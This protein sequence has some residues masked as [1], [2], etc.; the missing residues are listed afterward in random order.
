MALEID[1]NACY[2]DFRYWVAE[3]TNRP[4]KT[5]P[6]RNYRKLPAVNSEDIRN[7]LIEAKGSPVLAA[8]ILKLKRNTLATR[9][10]E[11]GRR[12]LLKLPMD[13]ER[14]IDKLASQSREYDLST[15]TPE[16]WKQPRG[17]FYCGEE[18][19]PTRPQDWSR[20]FCQTEHRKLY[21][22]T[23]VSKKIENAGTKKEEENGKPT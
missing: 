5:P 13:S 4:L 17:C 11:I 23:P 21:H 19:T 1:A 10:A 20:H 22:F 8:R 3:K 16:T 7:A 2:D 15:L 18:F 14:A 12:W 9:I 6:M